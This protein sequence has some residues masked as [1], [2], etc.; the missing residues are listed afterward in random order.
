MNWP[1]SKSEQKI[2]DGVTILDVSGAQAIVV[3]CKDRQ[4]LAPLKKH[5]SELLANTSLRGVP[6]LVITEDIDLSIL[7][8]K[9]A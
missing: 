3:R 6:V 9:I 8:R 5:L 7:T 4:A 2:P 1:W